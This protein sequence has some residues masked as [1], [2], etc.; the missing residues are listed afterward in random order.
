VK[1]SVIS[2][3]KNA[4]KNPHLIKDED[5]QHLLIMKSNLSHRFYT[6]KHTI[7]IK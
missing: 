3:K 5:F 6:H 1:I 4:Q 7:T 2:G